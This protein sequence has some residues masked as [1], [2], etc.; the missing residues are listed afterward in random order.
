[1]THPPAPPRF[2]GVA[3]SLLAP[4]VVL[5]AF[6]GVLLVRDG[7][8]S[9]RD[10]ALRAADVAGAVADR[11]ARSLESLP[12]ADPGRVLILGPDLHLRIPATGEW[13]PR[14]APLEPIADPAAAALWQDLQH[15]LED[16]DPERR[17]RVRALAHAF[18]ERPDPPRLPR[19][20]ALAAFA[21]AL[22]AD[23]SGHRDEAI[24]GFMRALRE[25]EGNLVGETGLPLDSLAALRLLELADGDASVLIQA[26][27]AEVSR[28]RSWLTRAA[29]SPA[30]DQVVAILRRG[31]AQ[32]LSTA[33]LQQVD[34]GVA[35]RRLAQT[36]VAHLRASGAP[37]EA[38]VA[39]EWI[40]C[41]IAVPSW[42]ETAETPGAQ[43]YLAV[44]QEEIDAWMAEAHL[45]ADPRGQFSCALTTAAGPDP[46]RGS[47]E[48][49]R[50]TAA[51]VSF[52]VGAQLKDEASFFAAQQQRT[53][54]LAALLA[55]MVACS[56][57][58]VV[59]ARRALVRQHELNLAKS[60][61][62]SA[63][64]HELRSPLGSLRLLAEGLQR[65]T[66]R[67]PVT[68]AEYVRLLGEESRRLGSLVENV[69]DYAR[70][71]Q[72]RKTFEREPT[73][74]ARLV[75]GTLDVFR[76]LATRANVGLSLRP[77]PAD[78][79]FEVHADGPALQQA[80]V[81]LLDNA[82]KHSPAG[83]T[84]D[85]ALAR[86]GP[87]V[88]LSVS[89]RGP[90]LP[91]AEQTRIFE[92]FYR[93]GSELRRESQ[94]IGIGLSIVRHIVE[95]HGGGV[96]VRSYPGQGATF[97]LTLPAPAADRPDPAP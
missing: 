15:A 63:V 75:E 51:G 73:D 97:T 36:L 9:R 64:S 1:M 69:L 95:A 37:A 19:H 53:V 67:D 12:D 60:N 94:G 90:G 62:L 48:A 20:R 5:T 82:L 78:A 70:I 71:E 61:F 46:P 84:I 10:A 86:N 26:W 59:A 87:V 31:E 3:V 43:A 65:G 58:A 56:A 2:L 52:R 24:R 25:S 44:R 29:P 16:Q 30:L 27:D 76:P 50:R 17:N 18:L 81:N 33:L 21:A 32:P 66:V 38:V 35:M 34:H 28:V 49:V 85:V 11:V 92:P 13:P 55:G 40:L 89:D 96:S 14:P 77:S 41:R 22:D 68:Q 45:G 72:G 74:L 57:I 88:S 93:R 23:R 8:A 83:G 7:R 4:V 42:F 80:L 6:A 47:V 39:P 79:P 54:L 91:E